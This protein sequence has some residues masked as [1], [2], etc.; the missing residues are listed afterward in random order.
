MKEM[1]KIVSERIERESECQ[2]DVEC[3]RGESRSFHLENS[4]ALGTKLGNTPATAKR[5]KCFL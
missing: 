4:A 5:Y 2:I 1:R 3:D